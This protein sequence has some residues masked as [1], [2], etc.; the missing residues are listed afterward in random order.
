MNALHDANLL[1]GPVSGP[2]AVLGA[3]GGVGTTAL[4]LLLALTPQSPH[5]PIIAVAR[6]GSP[7]TARL[8]QLLQGRVR[9]VAGGPE[10]ALT[11]AGGP[12]TAIVDLAGVI[13][14][15][16]LPLLK[17]GTREVECIVLLVLSIG[18][19]FRWFV[20]HSSR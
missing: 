4:Q 2:I 18:F 19:F 10:L 7:H 20:L 13:E 15:Q 11:T 17:E 3:T 5:S 8:E 1:Q 14:T 6:P 12:F 16:W 9:V